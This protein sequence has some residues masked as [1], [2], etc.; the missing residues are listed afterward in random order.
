V[1][2]PV[3]IFSTDDLRS[4]I[5]QKVLTRNGFEVLLLSRI[6]EV[7]E[8]I[9]K[10]NPTVVIFDT[11]G[12]FSEEIK[13][14]RNLCRTLEQIVAIVLGD[15]SILDGFEVPGIPKERCL[16][17]PLDPELIASRVE[18]V[19]SAKAREKGSKGAS[20]KSDLKR[21]LKLD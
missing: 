17:D 7:R 15:P 20:L 14:I 6:L 19:F 1:P 3:L 16:S 12:C 21:F 2:N 4:G 9:A 18:E 8:T 11:Y 10:Q 13:Q 5:I